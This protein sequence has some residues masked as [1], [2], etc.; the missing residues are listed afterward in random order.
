MGFPTSIHQ[1]CTPSYVYF[2]VSM[3]AMAIAIVQN[4]GNSQRYNLGMFSCRVPS[5]IGIFI[6][7]FLYIFFWTW[8]LNMICKDGHRGI[9]WFLVLLPFVLLFTIL[10]S[11][12]IY[13]K[14]NSHDGVCGKGK[15]CA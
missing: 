8:V 11:A 12:M 14:K 7:K 9:A 2:I 1:L 10:G 15:K 3:L 13:Q 6:V 5:C 4:L